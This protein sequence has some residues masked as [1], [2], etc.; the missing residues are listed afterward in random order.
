MGNSLYPIHIWSGQGK[1]EHQ[2]IKFTD[3]T[4]MKHFEGS[5]DGYELGVS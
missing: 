3:I 2:E 5:E 4:C 1:N